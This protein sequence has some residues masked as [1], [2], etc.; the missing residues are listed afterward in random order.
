MPA[1]T[2]LVVDDEEAVR[3]VIARTLESAGFTVLEAEHGEA[4]LSVVR[5]FS[6]CWRSP[7]W[8]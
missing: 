4:A 1:A 6:G 2:I 5:G 8:T 7:S 3:A